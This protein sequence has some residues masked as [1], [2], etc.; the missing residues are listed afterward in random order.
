[1]HKITYRPS[2]ED[3]SL[4]SEGG[5]SA[6]SAAPM[7][8]LTNCYLKITNLGAGSYKISLTCFLHFQLELELTIG[9]FGPWLWRSMRPMTGTTPK[10]Q[11]VARCGES[12]RAEGV[13]RHAETFETFATCVWEASALTRMCPRGFAGVGVLVGGVSHS[14]GRAA[15]PKRATRKHP[16]PRPGT[17]SRQVMEHE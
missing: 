4:R 14:S 10:L 15:R 6:E 2:R 9:F 12:E 5:Q 13:W 16:K 3:F 7:M 11:T 17:A 1:M 8:T